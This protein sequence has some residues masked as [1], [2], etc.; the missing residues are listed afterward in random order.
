MIGYKEGQEMN[1]IKRLSHYV[2]SMYRDI[3]DY[4]FIRKSFMEFLGYNIVGWTVSLIMFMI[5]IP[6]DFY[7]SPF[8]PMATVSIGFSLGWIV[9][10]Y[11]CYY[12]LIQSA[13]RETEMQKRYRF[14][15]GRFTK[16]S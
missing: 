12:P 14:L 15:Y 3:R 4:D 2:C 11:S 9:I 5:M 10:Y 16:T 8:L 1:R 13:H 6:A 7:I